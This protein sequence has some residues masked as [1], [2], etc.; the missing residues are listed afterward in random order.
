MWLRYRLCL[1]SRRL[2]A[3]R[4]Q[5]AERP[6][7]APRV[8]CFFVHIYSFID[9]G[10]FVMRG[11]SHT[12]VVCV[13]VFYGL[14]QRLFGLAGSIPPPGAAARTQVGV[15]STAM[16]RIAESFISPALPL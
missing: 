5:E 6:S 2:F 3:T 1:S 13:H 9:S 15:L 4:S 11:A 14:G 7:F 16:M 8:Y 12:I 10:L